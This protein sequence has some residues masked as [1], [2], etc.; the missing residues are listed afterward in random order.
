MR[1]DF[2][3]LEIWRLS[4]SFPSYFFSLFPCSFPLLP[5]VLV[6]ICQ[7]RRP[8]FFFLPFLWGT[9]WKEEREKRADGG[10]KSDGEE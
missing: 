9:R 1:V 7:V 4:T 10:D 8:Q 6:V 3:V 2:T 5:P